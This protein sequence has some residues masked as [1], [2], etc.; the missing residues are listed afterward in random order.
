MQEIFQ[1]LEALLLGAIP[2]AV[3]FVVL[4]MAYQWLIQGPLSATLLERRARTTGAIEDARNAISEAESKSADYVA[5][6]RHARAEAYKV[7]E[8]R[9]QKWIA[10]RDAALE[11]ARKVASQQVNEARRGIDAELGP[12]RQ[13]IESAVDELAGQVMRAVLPAAAGGSR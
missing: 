1:Q 9:L 2:T 11:A 4:V 3:L 10:E 5:Q 7:R 6:M 12:A 8:K 13:Q